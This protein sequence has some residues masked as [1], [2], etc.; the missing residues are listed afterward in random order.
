ME[1]FL[2]VFDCEYVCERFTIFIR[3]EAVMFTLGDVYPYVQHN[4][5]LPFVAVLDAVLPQTCLP[6]WIL[7]TYETSC[8]I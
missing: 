1:P 2:C 4:N 6:E 7:I 3:D 8:V 5:H